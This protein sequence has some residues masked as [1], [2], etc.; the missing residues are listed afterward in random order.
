MIFFFTF[1][2]NKKICPKK[3]LI[4][5]K[6]RWSEIFGIWGNLK[7]ERFIPHSLGNEKSLFH[8]SPLPEVIC[9]LTTSCIIKKLGYRIAMYVRYFRLRTG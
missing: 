1:E 3:Y 6:L 7:E 5:S 4:C 8:I 2:L 9:E